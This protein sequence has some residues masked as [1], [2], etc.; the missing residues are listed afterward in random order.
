LTSY[1]TKNYWSSETCLGNLVSGCCFVH[2]ETFFRRCFVKKLRFGSKLISD[3]ESALKTES[4]YKYVV[5]N[6]EKNIFFEKNPCTSP[7]GWMTT[8]SIAQSFLD[9]SF[10][11]SNS[12]E[13]LMRQFCVQ[14]FSSIGCSCEELSCIRTA[15]R[16]AGHTDRFY[17]VLTFWVHKKRRNDS[18]GVTLTHR[19]SELCKIKKKY[20]GGRKEKKNNLIHR[21]SKEKTQGI[22]WQRM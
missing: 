1:K 8:F 14:N 15:G 9:G 5:N 10:S 16:T 17:S 3:S 7:Q 2:F 20:F 6:S 22:D 19:T 21:V 12:T 18:S 11:S 13:I 4:I